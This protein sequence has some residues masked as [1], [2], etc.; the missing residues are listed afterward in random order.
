MSMTMSGL[1]LRIFRPNAP[2]SSS[3]SRESFTVRTDFQP[4]CGWYGARSPRLTLITS[5]P[6][7]TS[8]GTR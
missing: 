8:R 4:P 5:N 3:A 6:A 2:A 7:Q 1:S